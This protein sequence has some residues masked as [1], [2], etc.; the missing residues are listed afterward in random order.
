MHSKL[1]FIVLIT[2]TSIVFLSG[3][4]SSQ[5]S[6]IPESS[7]AV[8]Q[9]IAAPPISTPAADLRTSAPAPFAPTGPLRTPPMI[10]PE[11]VRPLTDAE[12]DRLINIAMD[13]PQAQ[14]RG[15]ASSTTI[16]WGAIVWKNQAMTEWG[17]YRTFPYSIVQ[18]GVP[19]PGFTLTQPGVTPALVSGE[20]PQ[21][22]DFY[23]EV[24]LFYQQY[25][26]HWTVI[27][28]I[29]LNTWQPV[30][31]QSNGVVDRGPGPRVTVPTTLYS[32]K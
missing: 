14:Q 24:R 17:Q 25:T 4:V 31:V 5:Q 21:D 12:K 1:S 6:L 27:V 23:P 18:T 22:A 29:N 30:L 11:G 9:P 20:V 16:A 26:P 2:L 3:C 13:T 7:K 32:P 10:N 28:D 15:A 8:D 19:Q